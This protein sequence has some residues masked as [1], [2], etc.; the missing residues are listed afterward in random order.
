MLVGVRSRASSGEASVALARSLRRQELAPSGGTHLIGNKQYGG[1]G[2][3]L[4]PVGV[5][6]VPPGTC[7][8][9][10]GTIGARANAKPAPGTCGFVLR[11]RV[12]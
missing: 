6:F 8:L 11:E 4:V 5:V 10:S 12:L 2:V 1:T 3:P 9:L 7:H